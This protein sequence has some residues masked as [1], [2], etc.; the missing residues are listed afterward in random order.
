[1]L[2]VRSVLLSAAVVALALSCTSPSS[3][4]WES[5]FNGRDLT[6]WRGF[7]REDA[8]G[9]WRAADGA[10]YREPG[11]E[12]GDLLTEREFENFELS[13]EWKLPEGGNSGIMFRVTE[14]ADQPWQTATEMQ[15]L[16]NA[17]HPD[18]QNPLTSAGSNYA[19]YAPSSDVT[20][21]V[22]E[23]NAVRILAEGQHVTF[24]MNDVQIVEF[25]IGSD[26]W[27]QRVAES[28]FA[29]MPL[30]GAS[31]RGHIDLQDHGNPVWF[32]NIKIRELR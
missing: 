22:G 28:K 4:D 6:G 27:K 7:G 9:G 25:E 13:L 14:D 16:D 17:G 23:W 3:D 5:L 18:G 20:K 19:L 31:A 29:E 30:Y 24:W 2:R 1:M 12:G 15:V 8:P 26:D 11:G 10:L 21:P 32:R